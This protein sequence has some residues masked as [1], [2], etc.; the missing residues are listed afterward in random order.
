MLL[1]LWT[2]HLHHTT[3]E[4][5]PYCNIRAYVKCLLGKTRLYHSMHCIWSTYRFRGALATSDY[6]AT[7]LAES[8]ATSTPFHQTE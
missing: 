2:T 5:V 1:T 8:G 6:P 7:R 3:Q 4:C